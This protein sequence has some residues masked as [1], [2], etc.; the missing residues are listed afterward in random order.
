MAQLRAK[1]S[2]TQTRSVFQVSDSDWQALLHA[3][4][5]IISR[6]VEQIRYDGPSG[7]VWV[8]LRTAEESHREDQAL[9]F[10]YKI[11][12]CRGCA[13]PAF[14]LQ[15]ANETLTRPRAWHAWWHSPTNSKHWFVPA[16]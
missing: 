2:G 14:R 11:P 8:K 5:E 4:A 7:T 16:R 6:L 9:T 15:P 3:D 13:L 10:E 1:M 12:G